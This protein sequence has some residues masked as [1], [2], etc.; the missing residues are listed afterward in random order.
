MMDTNLIYS[1]V[2]FQANVF[3][4]Q[5]PLMLGRI[6]ASGQTDNV[7]DLYNGIP[8]WNEADDPWGPRDPFVYLPLLP[9]YISQV[10]KVG[11]LV[12][13]MYQNPRVQYKNQFYVQ[14]PFASPM[15]SAF[16]FNKGSDTNLATGVQYAPFPPLKNNNGS[17]KD[18]RSKGI[19]PEP[20]DNA[21]L[22]RGS[23]DLVVKKDEV[24][25]RA[26]KTRD[27]NPYQLPVAY[28]KRGFL[29][30]SQ[31]NQT[32]KQQGFK[33][34][35]KFNEVIQSVKYL[36]EYTVLNPENV[37]NVFR[38]QINI[39]TFS[40]I[41]LTSDHFSL[42][43]EYSD[44]VLKEVINIGPSTMQNLIIEINSVLKAYNDNENTPYWFRPAETITKYLLSSADSGN[45]I[46]K[47]N[48]SFLYG[49][50]K[51]DPQA[52]INGSGLVFWKNAYGQQYEPKKIVEPLVEY[53]NTPQSISTLGG[54]MI[55]LLSHISQTPG[56]AVINLDGTLYGIPQEKFSDDIFNSTSST[57]R[58]EELL[59][60]L[61]LIVKFL[62]GH[63]HSY[64]LLPPVTISTNGTS[65]TDIL[66]EIQQGYQK[67]LNNNI[68]IN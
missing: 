30:I 63:T 20:G 56:K 19:F 11:E 5:D 34:Y 39:Y 51:P 67:I 41:A 45:D 6:R 22:G 7:Q 58:G 64:H 32:K 65:V 15:N 66:Q 35:T 44:T 36:I 14:G 29:Q 33:K 49:N 25:L 38:G 28:N 37:E 13:T 27:L 3:D 62:V 43:E 42:T 9:F 8:D 54:D 1:K 40:N 21:I 47:T 31:F 26:G 48:I 52:T 4:N 2:L 24:L 55:Y 50:V 10:P 46:E 59:K 23:A 53:V 60:L 61:S 12:Q 16:E 68:R 57:V 17:Y 18:D